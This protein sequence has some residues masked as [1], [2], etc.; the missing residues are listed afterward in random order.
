MKKAS[1]QT[2][3]TALVNYKCVGYFGKVLRSF[4]LKDKRTIVDELISRRNCGHVC[5][6]SA[7]NERGNIMQCNRHDYSP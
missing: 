2:L 5:R 1:E 3:L 7:N 4:N 6:Y